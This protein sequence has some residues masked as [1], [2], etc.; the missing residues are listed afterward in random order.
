M[1]G[2]LNSML[3]TKKGPIMK[4]FLMQMPM[5]FEVEYEGLMVMYGAW[6]EVDTHTGKAF[7]IERISIVDKDIQ[8]VEK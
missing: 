2:A 4:H 3:G 8:I 6:I 5:R 1:T 7:K